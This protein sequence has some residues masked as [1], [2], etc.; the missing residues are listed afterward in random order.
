MELYYFGSE[1]PVK[2]ERPFYGSIRDHNR[3]QIASVPRIIPIG[4]S[5]KFAP[6]P[7]ELCNHGPNQFKKQKSKLFRRK[8][9]HDK[10]NGKKNAGNA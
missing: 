2:S 10:I 7:S 1:I 3:S 6:V 8:M 5:T 4:S 9:R